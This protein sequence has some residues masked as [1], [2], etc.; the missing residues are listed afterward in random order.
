MQRIAKNMKSR[1]GTGERSIQ[2]EIIRFAIRSRKGETQK[3][4]KRTIRPMKLRDFPGKK[5]LQNVAWLRSAGSGLEATI[6]EGSLLGGPS[7]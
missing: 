1:K 4:A 7:P 3:Q 5:K 6:G 2:L